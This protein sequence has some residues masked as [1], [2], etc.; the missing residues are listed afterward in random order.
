MQTF[1]GKSRN[2]RVMGQ[3]AAARYEELFTAD[4][5]ARRYQQLYQSL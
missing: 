5:M 3:N 1:I 4:C 2:G